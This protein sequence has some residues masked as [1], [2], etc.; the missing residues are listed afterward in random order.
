MS[1]EISKSPEML[2]KEARIKELHQQIKKQRTTLKRLQTRLKNTKQEITDIQR[3]VSSNVSRSMEKTDAIHLEIME[4]LKA[5]KKL[6]GIKKADEEQIDMLIDEMQE[7]KEN[8]E[9]ENFRRNKAAEEDPEFEEEQRAKMHDIFQQFQVKPDEKEQRNIR[10][11]FITLSTNFHPDKARND[12]EQK[13]YHSL[14]QQI[15]EAYQSGDIDKLL[16]LEKIYLSDKIVDFTGKA[17]TVDM[18]TQEIERL[19]RDLN[20]IKNQ[21]KRISSEIKSLRKSE[22]GNILTEIN[23]AE[24]FGMGVENITEDLDE[25]LKRLTDLRDCLRQCIKKGNLD[26]MKEMVEAEMAQFPMDMLADLGMDMDQISSVKGI[27]ED[28]FDDD[29]FDDDMFDDEEEDIRPVLNPKFPIGTSVQI[30]KSVRYPFATEL[31]LKGW[32]G[33]IVNVYEVEKKVIYSFQFDSIALKALPK[34]LLNGIIDLGEDFGI[35]T[36]NVDDLKKTS[37]RDTVVETAR[38]YRTIL[39]RRQW[40]DLTKKDEALLQ[41]IM[42]NFPEKSDHENW[43]IWLKENI[44]FP[45]TGKSRGYYNNREGAILKVTGIYGWNEDV[46]LLISVNRGGISMDHPLIDIESRG[47]NKHDFDIYHEW[48]AMTYGL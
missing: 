26:P 38:T 17:V 16:E 15:N 9:F 40:N 10:K 31:N 47:K 19:T 25:N 39:H 21:A 27:F 8:D 36:V 6:K 34:I 24:K 11:I 30:K 14:M 22:L 12:K 42:L 18:L 13:D 4:L 23:R 7:M 1:K 37:P 48:C 5:C 3:E 43:E 29:M 45:F 20:F 44:K 2:Q 46:G 41:K 33:R 28:M 32:Q 35:I